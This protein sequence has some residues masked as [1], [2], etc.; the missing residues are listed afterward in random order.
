MYQPTCPICG[1]HDLSSVTTRTPNPI[2][3]INFDLHY[4]V[5]KTCDHDWLENEENRPCPLSCPLELLN[6][7]TFICSECCSTWR[8]ADIN[9]IFEV[10]D[11]NEKKE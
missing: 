7:R 2:P 5:C 1:G 10:I 8:I 3:G 4:Y 9:A 11:R 6:R